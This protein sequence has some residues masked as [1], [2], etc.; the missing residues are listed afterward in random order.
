MRQ[1]L[2][3]GCAFMHDPKVLLLDE[4]LTGLDPVGI[5][6][7]KDAIRRKAS[8]GTAVL[9]SSHL[10]AVVSEL[11]SR[12]IVLGHGKALAEGSPAEI[13]A[14]GPALG[15][16]PRGCGAG[17]PHRMTWAIRL[18]PR[19]VGVE[20]D[21]A[22]RIGVQE[23]GTAHRRSRGDRVFRFPG[24]AEPEEWRRGSTD[25]QIAAVVGALGLLVLVLSAWLLGTGGKLVELSSAERALLLPAPI[26]GGRVMD[27]KLMRLQATALGNALMW[28]ALT[29]GGQDWGTIARRVVA[30]WVVLTHA[31]AAP[32]RRGAEPGE[33]GDSSGDSTD[34][35]AVRDRPRGAGAHRAIRR[36]PGI[37]AGAHGVPG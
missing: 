12:V 33:C 7:M 26:S 18:P 5:R 9:L 30:F 13:A 24:L 35:R 11:C 21:A 15:W 27:V 1:K 17:P 8:D 22:D 20:P 4:P 25:T 29:S 10:L 14:R 36:D 3:L 37:G 31:A 28:T 16:H 32:H 2:A 23:A 34:P 6:R 19:A